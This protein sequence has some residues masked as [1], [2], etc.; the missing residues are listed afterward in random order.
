[1]KFARNA[2]HI[3]L[4]QV[5][6]GLISYFTVF[7]GARILD[8][9]NLA[10]FS[11]TWAIINTIAL[12]ALI[13]T[14]TY[15]PKLRAEFESSGALSKAN[16]ES[17]LL[18]YC[19]VGGLLAAVVSA[20][21]A[22]LDVLPVNVSELLASVFFVFGASIYGFKRAI[23]MSHGEYQKYWRLSLNYSLFGSAGLLL[24]FLM[25]RNSWSS[26]FLVLGVASVTTFLVTIDGKKF[27]P[28][29]LREIRNVITQSRSTGTHKVLGNLLVATFLSLLLSNGAVAFGLR[30]GVESRDLVSYSAMLNIVLIPMMMLN[31]FSAPTLNKAVELIHSHQIRNFTSLYVKAMSLYLGATILVVFVSV[32]FGNYLLH[33][34]VGMSYDV[35]PRVAGAIALSE[36]L[37]TLTVLPRLFLV[38][39]GATTSILRIWM[40]GVFFFVGILVTPVSPLTKIVIAPGIAGGVIVLLSSIVLLKNLK[41]D[42]S[43]AI[44]PTGDTSV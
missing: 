9:D 22:A 37:A 24:V 17:T 14:E 4:S 1:M 38:A 16:I 13:P 3:A 21:L 40:I 36:G 18:F 43:F 30:V 41:P 26:L 32:G 27:V 23:A 29:T 39:S 33:V 35:T 7:V 42:S 2:M 10:R 5:L 28:F 25:D 31:S 15:S 8:A 11:T 44:S 12:T 34:Y 19:L 20:I 6:V